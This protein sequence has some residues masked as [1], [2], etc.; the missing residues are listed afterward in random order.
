MTASIVEPQS[1]IVRY[2][3]RIMN[4]NGLDVFD[5]DFSDEFVRNVRPTRDGV[6]FKFWVNTRRFPKPGVYQLF[7][8]VHNEAGR[9]KESRP[10]T[11]QIKEPPKPT[12]PAEP[13]E[14]AGDD[15]EKG[16]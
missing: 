8:K 4:E 16:N 5:S 3:L 6:P 1:R 15:N 13:K 12:P 14:D 7:L 2:N 11:I 9:S 10:A